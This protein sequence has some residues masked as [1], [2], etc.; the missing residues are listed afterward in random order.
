MVWEDSAATP[1]KLASFVLLA[2]E[3][4]I[5]QFDF[6]KQNK[7]TSLKKTLDSTCARHDPHNLN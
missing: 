4:E 1:G 7:T 3:F 5:F 6:Q 2:S